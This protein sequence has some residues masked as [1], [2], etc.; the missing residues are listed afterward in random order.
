MPTVAGFYRAAIPLLV[1]NVHMP[2][3]VLETQHAA[4]A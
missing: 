1:R 2:L 3:A 4:R